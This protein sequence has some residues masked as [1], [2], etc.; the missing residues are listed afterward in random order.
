MDP[1]RLAA[2]LKLEPLPGEGG[3]VRMTY[4]DESLSTA[5]YLMIAPDFSALHQLTMTEVYH[6]Q[7]GAPASMLLL[8]PGGDIERIALSSQCPQ[9]VVPAGVWHGSRP[10][11]EW[12]LCGLT[13]VPPFHT[14]GL[15]LG[16]RTELTQGWPQA[17]AEIERLTRP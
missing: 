7:G 3:L 14:G 10:Q 8:H 16:S 12:T 5:L 6:W 4:A 2:S 9:T 1:H 15:T 13:V 17:A 11:G